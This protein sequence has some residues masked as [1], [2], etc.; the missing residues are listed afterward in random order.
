M[1]ASNKLVEQVDQFIRKYYKNQMLRGALLFVLLFAL[2]YLSVVSLEY[3]GRFNSTVRLVLLILFVVLNIIIFIRFIVFPLAKIFSFGEQISRYQAANIIGKF[4][5]EVNDKL[6]NTLQLNDHLEKQEGNLELLRASIEQNASK[7]SV[8]PFSTAINYKEN[9]RYLWYLIPLAI[10]FI[11]IGSIVPS[12]FKE[13]TERLVNYN[14]EFTVPAPF[15]FVLLT[16]NLTVEEGSAARIEVKVVPKQNGEIPERIYIES[17]QGRFL[18]EKSARNAAYYVFPKLKNNIAFRFKANEFM[19]EEFTL[20]VYGR[21]S[22]DHFRAQIE[23]PSYLNMGSQ[24]IE[25]INDLTIPEGTRVEWK[26]IARNTSEVRVSFRDTLLVFSENGFKL[27]KVFLSSETALFALQNKFT[28]K[29]DSIKIAVEVVKDAYPSVTMKEEIDSLNG[30]VRV[31]S[32]VATDD[33]GVRSVFFDYILT[34]K[35]GSQVKERKAVPG[36]SGTRSNVFLKLDISQMGIQLEDKLEY[37]FTVYDNDGVNGSK[38]SKS[39]VMVYKAP[40]RKE[41]DQKRSETKEDNKK[42]LLQIKQQADELK[43]SIDRLK[44]D[45]LNTKQP[46]WKEQQQL[47]QIM[48]QQEALQKQ[49]QK[50]NEK[51][52]ESFEEKESF[53]EVDEELLEQQAMLEE[54]LDEVMDEELEKLLKELEELLKE[55]NKEGAQ[56]VFDELEIKSEDAAKQMDRTMEMLKRM[57][58]EESMEAIEKGLDELAKEQEELR[59]NDEISK[60]DEISKQKEINDKYEELKKDLDELFE[61]NDELK[62]PLELDNLDKDKNEIQEDLKQAEENLKQ[63]N[64]KKASDEQK[65]ASDKMM[66]LSSKLNAMKQ[67][68]KQQQQEEDIEALRDLL[69]NLLKSSF[70]QEKNQKQMSESSE[71]SPSFRNYGKEQR[72]IIENFAIVEDSLE[73]LADRLPKISSFVNKELGIIK[74]NFNGIPDDIDE[75]RGRDLGIKQQLVMTSMN[76]LSLFLNESLEN[77]Q[78]QMQADQPGSGSCDNPGGKGKGSEGGELQNMKEMLKKQLENMKKGLNPGGKKPGQKE[79]SELPFGS[80]EAA[81]MAAQQNAMRKKLE[82]LKKEMNKDGSGKGNA[83]N[84]LLKELEEQE[85]KMVN[86]EWGSEMIQRQ[87]EILTR[88]LESEKAME[89]RGFSEERESKDGKIKESGNQFDFLEYKKLKEEQLELIRS[90]EPNFSKYYR[91]RAGEFLNKVS[92]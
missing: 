39:S 91:D 51:M 27:D 74:S 63:N 2:S 6:V 69:E 42:E 12:F 52:K 87:K 23:F 79:G 41:L 67:E 8:V 65:N 43:E 37:W 19:S 70:D 59:E 29:K 57:D 14:E 77:M 33:H 85:E 92:E 30:S 75:R 73:A 82:E 49:L 64:Q 18:M 62:R 1:E 4:F 13:G 58:V 84:D 38:F 17:S 26:G 31:L 86:K 54:L 25:N 88:L 50:V 28:E 80:K 48:D 36:I 10:I 78:A 7:L 15:E 40:S 45:V 46:S 83:L 89:E 16:D 35:D 5:P 34:R 60:D 68:A 20:S 90:F 55:Q 44:L 76:N 47:K 24:M 66:Q 72:N 71:T 21:S 32:G 61:K 22:M 9:K 53:S 56:E 3:L 11:F 81:K